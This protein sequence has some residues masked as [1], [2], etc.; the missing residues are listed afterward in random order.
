MDMTR[1]TRTAVAAGAV[2]AAAAVLFGTALIGAIRG[3]EGP[4]AARATMT[5]PSSVPATLAATPLLPESEIQAAV[6]ADLFEPDRRAPA[7]RYRLPGEAAEEGRALE[8]PAAPAGPQVRVV[9]AA[10]TGP[11]R[12]VALIQIGDAH[13]VA[14]AVGESVGGYVVA[15][16]SQEGAVLNGPAGRL[17]LAVEPAVPTADANAQNAPNGRG[18]GVPNAAQ[19]QQIIQQLRGRFGGGGGPGG[20]PFGGGG[21]NGGG[22]GFGRGG[23]GRRGQGGGGQ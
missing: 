12:G 2:A 21:G 4:P 17:A 18:G 15:S 7:Q 11:R 22:G 10:V 8:P 19:L 5:A 16:V 9:G 13:P 23:G 3:G 20:F 6:N 14:A 1:E